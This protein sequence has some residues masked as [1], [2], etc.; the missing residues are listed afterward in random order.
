LAFDVTAG[1]FLALL[2][3][4]RSNFSLNTDAQKTRAG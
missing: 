3:M 4:K 1:G 2:L